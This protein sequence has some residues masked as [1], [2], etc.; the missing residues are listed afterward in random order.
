MLEPS[1]RGP[2][3]PVQILGVRR[4]E[5]NGRQAANGEQE[6]SGHFDSH[7]IKV[8]RVRYGNDKYAN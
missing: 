4:C 8:W 7:E 2:R 1:P 3:Q 6:G 5:K